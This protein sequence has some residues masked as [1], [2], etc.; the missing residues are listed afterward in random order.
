MRVRVVERRDRARVADP[1]VWLSV[2][3]TRLDQ[4]A[5]VVYFLLSRGKA[6][7]PEILGAVT[8]TV[9]EREKDL[10]RAR[11]RGD[12]VPEDDDER[13]DNEDDDD[14]PSSSSKAKKDKKGKRRKG[15]DDEDEAEAV[16]SGKG[17][18]TKKSTC[19]SSFPIFCSP[20]F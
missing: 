18:S 8:A 5:D 11:N 2:A 6:K 20:L 14:A 13:S 12:D 10:E 1:S 4:A 15:D 9:L 7:L 16:S 19:L 17:L 3:S